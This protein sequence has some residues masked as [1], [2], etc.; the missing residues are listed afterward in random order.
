MAAKSDYAG[1]SSLLVYIDDLHLAARP[2]LYRAV[3]APARSAEYIDEL[4]NGEDVLLLVAEGP[5]G[6]VGCAIA[7]LKTVQAALVLA[8]R[9]FVLMDLLVTHPDHRRT[10][11]GASLVRRVEEWAEEGDATSVELGVHEFNAGARKFYE[12]LGYDTRTRRLE[13]RFVECS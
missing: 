8:G 10:G 12:K 3:S 4:I 13:K 11:V 1:I 5:A 6:L 7:Y 2:D 9:K